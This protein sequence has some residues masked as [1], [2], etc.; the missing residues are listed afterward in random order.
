M[1]T[2]TDGLDL[3]PLPHA[4]IRR[5]TAPFQ[6]FL[7]VQAASGIVLIACTLL[8]MLAAN[9]PLA[10][11]WAAFW[12]TDVTLRAGGLGLS[13]PLWY[14]VNDGLMAIFFF[15]VGL[16]IKRELATGELSDRRKVT[17]P[18]AAAVG[19][20]VLPA[21]IHAVLSAGTVNARGWAV[22]MATDIAFVV[23]CLALLGSRVP[24]GLKILIL[25]MAIVDDLLAVIVIALF[26]SGSLAVPW[27]AAAG[28]G[29][30]LIALLNR[31]GVRPVPIY[32]L[33]G[34]FVWLATLKSGIHPTV[35]GAFLGLMTPASAWI[36]RGSAREVLAVGERTLAAAPG[37]AH[38]V[39]QE[40]LVRVELAA[41]EARSPEAAPD[42]ISRPSGSAPCRSSTTSSTAWAS[43]RFSRSSF[44]RRTGGRRSPT[45]GRSASSFAPSSSSASPSTGS[46]R[47]WRPSHPACSG[48][49]RRRWPRWATTG[50]DERSTGSSTP[51]APRWPPSSWWRSASASASNSRGFTTTR[52]A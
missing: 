9:S 6:R 47:R 24:H 12:E 29:L 35:A 36:A 3:P 15:V 22:P 37:P 52:R 38:D 51:T 1:R 11:R 25:S 4:P 13:Y 40:V 7:G 33:V 39:E 18:M 34:A 5:V 46:R 10:G 48:S 16:E 14:W 31:M 42:R 45:P 49:R 44:R 43:R 2:S 21:V 26:Y 8:A 17:L 28:G 19:G 41:R 50:S 20:A 27:L 30:L 32:V 23:G